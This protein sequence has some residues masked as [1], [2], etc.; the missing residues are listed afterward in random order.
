MKKIININLSGRVIPIEDAAYESLQKYIDSLRRYFINEEGRDEIINDIESRMAELM[1]DKIRKGQAAITEADIEEIIAS[2]GRVE[3]FEEV[4]SGDN[5]HANTSG[6][7]SPNF[8]IGGSRFKG[9]LYRDTSD[10]L[11][12]GVCSG[13]ANYLNVDPA[14]VRLLFAIISFG[15]YGFGIIIYIALWIILPAKNLETFVGKRLFRNPDDKVIG[16]VAGGLGAYF[17][18]SAN[19]IRIIF[20]API[21]LNV[22]LSM[23]N[24]V[25]DDHNGIN[26]PGIFV[27]SLT[28]TFILAY[29]IL[30][31]VL[32]EARSPY[33]KMEM[34]GEN[35]DVNRIRQNVKDEME[36]IKSRAES[37]SEEVRTSAK[38]FSE[39]AKKFSDTRGK[40][41]AQEFSSAAK[42][43]A[44]GLGHA[45]GVI[46]KAFMIFVA[47]SI[48]FGLFVALII[49]VFGGGNALWS[50]KSGMLNLV[51][52]G[53]LQ[54]TYFW[55][56]IIFFL[57]VP[58]AGFII[59]LV[60]RI[61]NVR[62]Q[63]NYLGW[64]FSAL[65]TIGWVA[66]ILLVSSLVRDFRASREIT[67]VVTLQQPADNRLVVNV[68]APEIKYNG[69]LW[70][71]DDDNEGWDLTNDS[72]F[73]GNV[74]VSVVKSLDSLYSVN[75]TKQ[76][77]G[78]TGSEAMARASK[79]NYNVLQNQNQLILGS[80]YGIA[81]NDKFRAQEVE[82]EIKVPVGKKINFDA[83]VIQKFHPVNVRVQEKRRRN[84]V[85]DYDIDVRVE[86]FVFEYKTNVDYVMTPWGD[87]VTVEEASITPPPAPGN[88]DSLNRIIE[89]KER[90]LE[91]LKQQKSSKTKTLQSGN[92]K[93][94]SAIAIERPF[95]T[96]LI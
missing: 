91:I 46:V 49:L 68:P 92:R 14:V 62:S 87:L 19:T 36:N 54:K 60:R 12:G 11:L 33:E 58:L 61:M 50:P 93:Q 96:V 89:Q 81:I 53:G 23:L 34:R 42:P 56:T 79:I 43:V 75:L 88:T 6:N 47:G 16:G 85:R 48:A 26:F 44:T 66:M 70:F 17:K 72:F 4:E 39:R 67:R 73:L 9:R 7:T 3:D 18:K 83:S 69:D 21:L 77:R 40:E 28:G 8:T 5:T 82:I 71:I 64:I 78:R 24:F 38:A 13:I 57:L 59:W 29:I 15:G 76:S 1:N 32:P 90:E 65:W 41:F 35:V 20:A 80:G 2:M 30:W 94:M 10:K 22:L 31:I 25:F 86:P 95:F 37:F 55:G 52:D 51:L 27:G 84:R 63:K 74:K 45:I